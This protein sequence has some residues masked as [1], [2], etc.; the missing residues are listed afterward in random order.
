MQQQSH[1]GYAALSLTDQTSAFM[2]ASGA[3]PTAVLRLEG[4]MTLK[5]CICQISDTML[6]KA[7]VHVE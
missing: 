5:G 1:K 4:C 2:L 3:L 6:G 7:I